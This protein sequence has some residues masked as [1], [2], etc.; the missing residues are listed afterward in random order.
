MSKPFLNGM[1]INRFRL[2]FSFHSYRSGGSF[3]FT[4]L[5][6]VFLLKSLDFFTPP[7]KKKMEFF[8]SP[9]FPN[10]FGWRAQALY[11]LLRSKKRSPLPQGPELEK[12]VRL[13]AA[14]RLAG[15]VA[16]VFVVRVVWTCLGSKKKGCPFSD[17]R[18]MRKKL[19]SMGFL[20]GVF[21]YAPWL[22]FRQS[23]GMV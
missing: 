19:R 17:H 6:T 4:L 5:P 13:A 7:Q 2:V 14:L 22:G 23:I 21:Y 11:L 15:V 1:R 3:C 10:W 16:V 18:K 20:Y 12:N 9:L 8:F